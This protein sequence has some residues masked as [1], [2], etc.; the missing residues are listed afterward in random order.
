MEIVIAVFLGLWLVAAA[1]L[2]LVRLKKDYSEILRG[3]E[4]K[5]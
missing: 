5:K 4:D 2:A 3:E 1:V